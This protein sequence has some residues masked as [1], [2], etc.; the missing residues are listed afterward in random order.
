MDLYQ[1]IGI[2]SDIEE[3][4]QG[5]KKVAEFTGINYHTLEYHFT[6]S[7][8]NRIKRVFNDKYL[9]KKIKTL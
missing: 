9:I 4:A 2:E 5:L 8:K 6:T 3:F 1:I 7:K